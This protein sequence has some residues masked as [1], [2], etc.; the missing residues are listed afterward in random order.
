MQACPPCMACVRCQDLLPPEGREWEIR[1]GFSL[2]FLSGPGWGPA[3]LC[4]QPGCSVL[5]WGPRSGGLLPTSGVGTGQP[6][7]D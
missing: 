4:L 3:T 5:P 2:Q 6:R 7:L 1:A